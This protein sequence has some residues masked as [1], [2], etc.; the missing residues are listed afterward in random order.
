MFA[1]RRSILAIL[2]TTP[3]PRQSHET[4]VV[5]AVTSGQMDARMLLAGEAPAGDAPPL[6]GRQQN[7]P[8]MPGKAISAPL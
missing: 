8:T 4:P 3:E 2:L 7:R 6:A 1:T 5:A